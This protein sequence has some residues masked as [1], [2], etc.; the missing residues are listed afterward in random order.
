VCRVPID[1]EEKD[2]ITEMAKKQV[3]DLGTIKIDAKLMLLL[4]QAQVAPPSK[5]S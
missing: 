1:N 4:S 5:A 2:S 3:T